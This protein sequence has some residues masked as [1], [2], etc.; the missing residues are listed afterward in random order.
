[1]REY[2]D[3]QD[4]LEL[5]MQYCTDD[6]GTCSKAGN[7]LREILDDIESLPTIEISN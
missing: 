6:D 5:V 2:V 4:V 3:L 7:D 1:M